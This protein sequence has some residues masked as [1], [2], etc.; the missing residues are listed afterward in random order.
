MRRNKLFLVFIIGGIIA[1]KSCN[2]AKVPKC[3]TGD[4]GETGIS[5]VKLM[6]QR[7]SHS[8]ARQLPGNFGCSQMARNDCI[9]VLNALSLVVQRLDRF[10]GLL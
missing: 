5:R 2:L 10:C 6:W 4:R 3:T 9:I 8:S 1:T 7:H